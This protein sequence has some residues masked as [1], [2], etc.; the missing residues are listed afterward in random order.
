MLYRLWASLR[1][2]HLQ[3]SVKSWVRE[4]VSSVG[5]GVSSVDA[6]FPTALEIEEVLSGACDYQLHVLVAS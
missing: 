4:S 2:S 1:L 5:T 3:D 6:W